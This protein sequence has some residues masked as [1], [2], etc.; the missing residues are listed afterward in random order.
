M[1]FLAN[2]IFASYSHFEN[3]TLVWVCRWIGGWQGS[4]ATRR[5]RSGQYDD[6]EIMIAW[7]QLK[8]YIEDRVYLSQQMLV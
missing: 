4:D 1:N 6:G 7:D 5:I 3:M 2:S 8:S